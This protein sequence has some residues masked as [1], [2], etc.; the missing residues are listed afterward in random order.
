LTMPS[1]HVILNCKIGKKSI[2]TAQI[3]RAK[4]KL[5]LKLQ[6]MRLFLLLIIFFLSPAA[7]FSS[8][9]RDTN[10]III[11]LT[12]LRADHLK[13][14]GYRLNTAP[15]IDKFSRHAVV[16]EHAITQSNWTLPAQ[17]AIFTSKYVHS[18]GIYERDRKLSAQELTLA[19]ILK[20][21][22][23]TT[24]AFVG[25]LDMVK[26]YGLDQGF[27]LY[28]DDT[29]GAPVGSFRDIIPK[30]TS[31]VKKN[32]DKRFFLFLQG[33]DIHPP[34]N[35][36]EPFCSMYDPNYNGVL[37]GLS[38]DYRLLKNIVGDAMQYNGKSI[39]LTP[40]DLRHVIALYDGSISYADSYIGQLLNEI[41]KLQLA[42][43]TLI[44]I[45]AEHGEELSDHGSFDRF[46]QGNLYDEVVRVPLIIKYPGSKSGN[47]RI[48]EQIQMI[49][50]VPTVL[51]LLRIPI[52]PEIQ[53]V[54]L[55]PLF[56]GGHVNFTQFAYAEASPIKWAI[57]TSNWKLIANSGKY[58]LYDLKHDVAE[59]NNLADQQ[60]DRVYELV[61][62]LLD[63]RKQTQADTGHDITKIEITDE[64]KKKLQAAGYW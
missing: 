57:R 47:M 56:T 22:G 33:Y 53:G 55:A 61:Q 14:Y 40:A 19:E 45:T 29:N 42:D 16:F 38:I 24:A 13:S 44:I 5:I 49:D 32:K 6:I 59:K 51:G 41:E 17:S 12:A 52:N 3:L 50:I 36:P 20:I 15:H 25:G 46:G 31:W 39:K 21:Y 43:K 63:W 35:K 58:E 60:S 2:S 9:T 23:Y 8:D 4:P 1:F 64:M 62:K 37:S 10:V 26:T 34:F 11:S 48:K 28:D 27:D 54:N 7:S 30:A 18:H